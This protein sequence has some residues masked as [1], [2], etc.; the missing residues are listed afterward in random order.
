MIK[1][2]AGALRLTILEMK[3][4][5]VS[6][7]SA[8][9]TAVAAAGAVFLHQV[10][11][12]IGLR[13]H[14]Q[15]D[16]TDFDHPY[17]RRHGAIQIHA[18]GTTGLVTPEFRVHRQSDTLF[19]ATRGKLVVGSNP[20]YRVEMDSGIAPHAPYIVSGTRVM[21]QRDVLWDTALAPAVRKRMMKAV[22]R[23]LGKVLRTKSTLRFGAGQRPELPG[24][25]TLA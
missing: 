4:T 14:S 8:A 25:A 22:V 3:K 17:A 13:D 2:H 6:E 15:E 9:T 10:K 21:L 20:S 18:T 7:K 19:N 5:R 1:V 16:L 12:N 23:V 24:G 11:K